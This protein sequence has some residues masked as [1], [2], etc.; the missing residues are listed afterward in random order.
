MK[1]AKFFCAIV[2]IFA[3]S[4]SLVSPAAAVTSTPLDESDLQ[5]FSTYD[6][7]ATVFPNSDT[8]GIA[9][10]TANEEVKTPSVGSAEYNYQINIAPDADM[11]TAAVEVNLN[12]GGVCY[13]LS[14]SGDIYRTAIN[15]TIIM[16]SGILHGSVDIEGIT[17]EVDAYLRKFSVDERI[18]L[19]ITLVPPDYDTNPDARLLFL[20]IGTSLMSGSLADAYLE[21]ASAQAEAAEKA[22]TANTGEAVST[23][24]T[25][26]LAYQ[27]S[28]FGYTRDG[29]CGYTGTGGLGQKLRVYKDDVNK[30]FVLLL[31]SYAGRFSQLLFPNGTF[32]YAYISAYQLGLLRVGIDSSI[33]GI[34]GAQSASSEIPKTTNNVWTAVSGIIYAVASYAGYSYIIDGVRN[35]LS[36]LSGS[37]T[38]CFD[39]AGAYL[40]VSLSV[41]S[42]ENFDNTPTACGFNINVEPGVTGTYTAYSHLTYFIDCVESG[43]V[44]RTTMAQANVTISKP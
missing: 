40:H 22:S 16:F 41:N 23:N 9:A 1:K 25:G 35:M 27:A 20:A 31:N 4:V 18:N 24:A 28:S 6:T 10:A 36:G 32:V 30:R 19:G 42:R 34:D 14:L 37:V 43:F 39:G 33:G 17:Y 13:P 11:G 38:K 2:L 29:L 12:I 26:S 5:L 7:F 21:Y 3:L 15:D 44:V 8:A